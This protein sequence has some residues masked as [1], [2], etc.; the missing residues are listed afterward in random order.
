MNIVDK[1]LLNNYSTQLESLVLKDYGIRD[2]IKERYG[3]DVF[4]AIIHTAI[5]INADIAK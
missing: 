3:F 5:A 2:T 1:E 4:N